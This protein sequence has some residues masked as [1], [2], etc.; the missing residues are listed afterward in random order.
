MVYS[1]PIKRIEQ[2]NK[3][4]GKMERW[5]NLLVGSV[6][7]VRDLRRHGILDIKRGNPDPLERLNDEELRTFMLGYFDGD[8]SIYLVKP[9]NKPNS[10]MW[11]ICCQYKSI[12]EYLLSRCPVVDRYNAV[13]SGTVWR[14]Q[15][16]GNRIVPRICEWLYRDVSVCLERKRKLADSIV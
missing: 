6:E 13:W 15:Y 12:P 10:W 16:C 7:M 14:T 1:K 3:K 5:A 2:F 11:Y 4:R 8:G 9:K